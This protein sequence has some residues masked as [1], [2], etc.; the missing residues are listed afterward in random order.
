[1]AVSEFDRSSRHFARSRRVSK[2]RRN[3]IRFA[4]CCA[5]FVNRL[6]AAL[7]ITAY[8]Q[9]MDVKLGQFIGCRPANTARSSCNKCCRRI[10]GHLQ[11]PFQFSC[12]GTYD[13]R[14]RRR[15][16]RIICFWAEEGANFRRAKSV[17]YGADGSWV[18]GQAADESPEVPS[19]RLCCEWSFQV[20]GHSERVS[21]QAGNPSVKRFDFK[22]ISRCSAVA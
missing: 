4:S 5:D 2:V 8:D 18:I 11:F 17:V 6:P 19:D 12:N 7:H 9:D 16:S 1:M 13:S 22:T 15:G 20:W 21:T 3:K 14:E 10:S